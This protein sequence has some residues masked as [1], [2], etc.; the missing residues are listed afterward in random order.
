MNSVPDVDSTSQA[1]KNHGVSMNQ[2]REAV[3]NAQSH[4]DD[5]GSGLSIKGE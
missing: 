5:T 3:N 1:C 4:H 2:A